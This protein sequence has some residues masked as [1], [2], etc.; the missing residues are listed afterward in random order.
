MGQKRFWVPLCLGLMVGFSGALWAQQASPQ[1]EAATAQRGQ[2]PTD[3][4]I[5]CAGFFARQPIAP[6]LVVLSN[7]DGGFKNEYVDRDIIYLNKGKQAISAP[8]GQYILV[9]PVKDVNPVEFFKGQRQRIS[10]LGTLYAEVGRIQVRIVHEA[11]ATAEVLKTCEPILAGDIAIPFAS[12]PAPPYRAEKMMD[13]FA[14]ASGKATAMVVAAKD[15]QSTLGEGNIVY[16][17]VGK[18]QGAQV[19]SYLRIFRSYAAADQDAFQQAARNYP[20]EIMGVPEG[21]KLT[22][23][24]VAS[25]PRKVLGEIILLS[26]EEG[27]S[28][29]I[30]TFA[31]EDV[32]PGDAA[33]LE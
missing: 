24:E 11:S 14:P 27:S 20:T 33:E 10:Q 7:E 8:G 6:N 16:L 23:A 12:R 30:I 19:G 32:S 31:R 5:Y 21:R 17:N 25:L 2:A 13:H 22:P 26:V 28:T 29:G 9:R 18:N 15:F 3:S 1:G 4:D